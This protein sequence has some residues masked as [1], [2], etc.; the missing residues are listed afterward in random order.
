MLESISVSSSASGWLI[1]VSLRTSDTFNWNAPQ[2]GIFRDAHIEGHGQSQPKINRVFY[3]ASISQPLGNMKGFRPVLR[4]SYL[5]APSDKVR[6]SDTWN[7][8]ATKMLTMFQPVKYGGKYRSS[9][10]TNKNWA[11]FENDPVTNDLYMIY[12]GLPQFSHGSARHLI[13]CCDD[14]P[15]PPRL[16]ANGASGNQLQQQPRAQQLW[17]RHHTLETKGCRF[18]LDFLMFFCDFW[19]VFQSG[20][21]FLA[22]CYILEQKP[23]LCWIWELKFAICTVHQFSMVLLDFSMVF[24]DLPKVFIDCSIVFLGYNWFFHGFN[25]FF[26]A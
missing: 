16:R 10:R 26:F 2:K 6:I 25:R 5:L 8:L 20:A 11:H 12:H 24:I 17:G 14:A 4:T 7:H 3:G 23:V 19:I 9:F 21:L 15:L 22:I 18:C 13:D 1:F